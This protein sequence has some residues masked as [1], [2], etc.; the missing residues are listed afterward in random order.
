MTPQ[1]GTAGTDDDPLDSI[2]T[3]QL[4]VN[5][6]TIDTLVGLAFDSANA[7]DGVLRFDGT[8][9]TNGITDGSAKVIVGGTVYDVAGAEWVD[10]S[11][12]KHTVDSWEKIVN[13]QFD[14]TITGVSPDPVAPGNTLDVTVDVTN[15]GTDQ[16]TQ[17][18]TLD[19]NNGVGQV[20]SAS[21]TL[22][23]G[24]STT[25]TLSWAVPSSQAVQDYQATVS[26]DDDAASQTVTVAPASLISHYTFDSA[27]TSG[28]TAIDVVG[29]N[30][31]TIQGATTGVS[32]ANQ[33]YTTN[34]A[35]SFDGVDDVVDCGNV[36]ISGNDSV[37]IACWVRTNSTSQDFFQGVHGFHS[38]SASGEHFSFQC[39]R[40]ANYELHTRGN[41]ITL[42]SLSSSW[43]H[44]TATY[45]GSGVVAYVN[46][47]QVGS[48][49]ITLSIQDGVTIG[50][51]PGGDRHF[52]G[53][54]D[55]VR[56]Y[57]KALTST[58]VSNLYNNGRI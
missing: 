14:V 9:S 50:E 29:S 47:S 8:G 41:G 46:G 52:S 18:V 1:P 56:V 40:G 13:S 3:E 26:S 5:G 31:G 35:Y 27:D 45:D 48:L 24:G 42:T 20:D 33:T 16:D 37:S 51:R 10:Q 22:S 7:S 58:E 25:T 23:G 19:I 15:N 53:D 30:D 17:T 49:D 57:D 43:K 54:I 44:L 36:G 11:G 39:N 28:S 12:T 55:D 2:E 38:G 32:G 6:Q 34:E 4:V 21:V